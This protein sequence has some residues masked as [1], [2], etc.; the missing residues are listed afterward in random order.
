MS[1]KYNGWTNYE[2]WAAALWIDND[3]GLQTMFAERAQ[4]LVDDAAGE[5]SG[6]VDIEECRHDCVSALA[7]EI[8]ANITDTD[9]GM[10]DLPN[11]LYSD[12]LSHAM[13]RVE[14]REIAEHFLAD[15]DVTE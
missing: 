15:I 11:S 4:E 3:G 5:I 1:E 14:W 12:L 7:D 6:P 9:L 2:T 10:P 8:E 13:D